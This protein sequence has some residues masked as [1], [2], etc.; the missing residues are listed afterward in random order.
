MG[1]AELVDAGQVAHAGDPMLDAH[2]AA[3]EK[4]RQGDAWR[5]TRRGAGHVDGMYAAA[6]AAHLARTLPPPVRPRIRVLR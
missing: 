6:G 1:F 5:F 4:L 3:A 2:A